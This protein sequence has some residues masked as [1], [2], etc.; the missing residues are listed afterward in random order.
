MPEV[1]PVEQMLTTEQVADMLGVRP[2]TITTY[3]KRGKLKPA[4]KPVRGTSTMF[5]PGEVD[6]YLK[7]RPTLE[8]VPD[9]EDDPVDM[10]LA[11]IEAGLKALR[12]GLRKRDSATAQRAIADLGESLMNSAKK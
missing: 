12:R 3:V 2:S 6:R 11:Q 1:S 4:T 9:L 5:E 10:A 8:S 7:D